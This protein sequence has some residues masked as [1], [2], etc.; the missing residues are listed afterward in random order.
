MADLRV[1][2]ADVGYAS[3]LVLAAFGFVVVGLGVKLALFPLHAWKPDA[4]ASAPT[5]VAALLATLGSTVAGYAL[6]RLTFG[7]F[8]ADFLA[9]VP[10]A[11]TGLLA[12]GVVGIVT[13]G[14]LTLR[15]SGLRRMLSYS[16]ILQFGLVVVGISVATPAAVTGA[17]LLLVANAVAK[18]GLFAAAGLLERTTGTA[19]IAALAGRG[20]DLPVTSLS[21]AVAFASLVGLPPTLGFAGKWFVTLATVDVRAW[22]A[23]TVVLA[24][25]LVSLA[26]AGRVVER[27]YLASDG[28]SRSSASVTTDGGTR[29][30]RAEVRTVAFVALAGLSTLLLGLG[31]TELA[32]WLSPV[33]EG[34]L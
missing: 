6:V 10:L 17:V 4:Y 29:V 11:S 9:A 22:V 27:L 7:V 23:A 8:T 2:I 33:V 18:G 5:D 24:S 34:W 30:E 12:V 1:A 26:Y 14:Y 16:S 32:T 20:Y 3:P 13:G 31:S 25:T 28:H 19:S 15:Q 21:V